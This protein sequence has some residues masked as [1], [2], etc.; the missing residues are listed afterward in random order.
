MIFVQLF[1]TFLKIGV[2]TIGSGYSMLVLAERYLVEHYQWITMEEFSDIVAIAEVTPGPIII[3]LATFV[4]TKIAGVRGALCATS[5]LIVVPLLC[6]MI[7]AFHYEKLKDLPVVQN[8]FKVIRPIAI[9]FI[10]VALIRLSRQSITDLKTAVIAVAAVVVTA[11][12]KINPI[13]TIAAGIL[14][15]LFMK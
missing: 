15:A 12:F 3:N 11:V 9:G 14:L 7:I 8:I 4:G 6:I 2:F 10:A 13:Y 5:G 1:F